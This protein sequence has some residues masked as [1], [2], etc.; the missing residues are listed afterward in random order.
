MNFQLSR[1]NGFMKYSSRTNEIISFASLFKCWHGSILKRYIWTI[2]SLASFSPAY[3]HSPHDTVQRLAISPRYAADGTVYALVRSNLLKSTDNGISWKRLVQGLD[4][5]ASLNSFAVDPIN[6]GILYAS[7]SKDGVYRSKDAGHSWYRA[8]N[9]LI[10][11]GISDIYVSLTLGHV[12]ALATGRTGSLYK[13]SDAGA[14]WVKV[15]NG[16]VPLS[17]MAGWGSQGKNI[18]IGDKAGSLYLSQNA[19]LIWV[20]LH[21]FTACGV[22]NNI[23]TVG[24]PAIQQMFFVATSAC[25]L[26]RTSDGGRTFQPMNV[27]IDDLNIRG[28][29][30]SPE[31]HND[32][33]VFLATGSKAIYISRNAGLTWLLYQ[34]G[35]TTNP[36]GGVDNNF[37]GI[38]VSPNFKADKTVFLEGFDGTFKSIDGGFRWSEMT[39]MPKTLIQSVA[40]SPNYYLDK[41]LALTSYV[42]G[43]YR[44]QNGGK[45][46][47]SMADNLTS[48]NSDI[49]FSPSYAKDRTIFAAIESPNR[50]AKST[51]GGDT[52]TKTDIACQPTIIAPS[53][54]FF[55]DQTIFAACRGGIILLRSIDGG[56][57]FEPIYH[58]SESYPCKS[59]VTSLVLSPNFKRD[60]MVLL[61][62][63]IAGTGP[64]V[65]ISYDGGD[66]W[67]IKA[68]NNFGGNIKFS[69]SP[70]YSPD[71]T[72][73]H[74]LFIGGANGLFYSDDELESS[75]KLSG[76]DKGVDGYVEELAV[77]PNFKNDNTIL[78]SIRGKGLFKSENRGLGFRA[79]GTS[80][81]ANNHVFGLWDGFPVNSSSMIRF[82]PSYSRDKTIYG[83]SSD[84]LFLSIDAGETWSAILSNR[85]LK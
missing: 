62:T 63:T 53:P 34:D 49:I 78:I 13:S 57:T 12:Y 76:S 18:L 26:F 50:I 28:I 67:Q 21:E 61:A 16:T 83:S 47:T 75:I 38:R 48:R 46:W 73:D 59:C 60:R 35:I 27:G 72:L 29:A 30:I 68:S 8:G 85:S 69:F 3:A 19:G 42:A 43:I 70:D 1:Y 64:V 80:L 56:E 15:Y 37:R 74:A 14:N 77:S 82:S 81:I 31:F 84:W 44:S 11:V 32:S 41:S 25:G 39:V 79:V 58:D 10:N 23:S 17:A 40:L 45:S 36:Q 20:K 7:S 2:L 4:N 51:D 52:W 55:N 5:I 22:I 54:D 6:P 9:G 66:T 71:H 65:Q 24:N 33:T